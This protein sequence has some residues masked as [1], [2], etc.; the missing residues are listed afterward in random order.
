MPVT[1]PADAP[2]DSLDRYMLAIFPAIMV[3]AAMGKNRNFHQ[4]YQALG[5]SLMAFYTLLFLLH[6]PFV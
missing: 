2:L 4:V 1:A 3:L 6:R 5:Y